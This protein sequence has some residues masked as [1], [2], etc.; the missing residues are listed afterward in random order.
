MIEKKTSKNISLLKA[1]EDRKNQLK[2]YY[3]QLVRHPDKGE[4]KGVA[5]R[6]SRA[7]GFNLVEMS[8][9]LSSI[10]CSAIEKQAPS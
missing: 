2:W 9:Q 3:S 6:C 5:N 10:L 7:I 1:F 8:D 4:S